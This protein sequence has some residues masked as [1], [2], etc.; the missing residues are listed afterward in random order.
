MEQNGTDPQAEVRKPSDAT[1]KIGRTIRQFRQ[2]LGLS[3]KEFADDIGVSSSFIRKLEFGLV[4]S[5]ICTLDKCASTFNLKLS[6]LLSYH[7]QEE[8]VNCEQPVCE[9]DSGVI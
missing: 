8:Q 1:V 4:D 5:D 7:L 6:D 2:L 3:R 9:Q